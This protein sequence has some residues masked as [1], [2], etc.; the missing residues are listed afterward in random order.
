M[1]GFM[2]SRQLVL[3]AGVYR[4]TWTQSRE[5]FFHPAPLALCMDVRWLPSAHPPLATATSL[6]PTSPMYFLSVGGWEPV[7]FDLTTPWHRLRTRIAGSA[8]I[9]VNIPANAI[10]RT[11]RTI[12]GD[13]E[14]LDPVPWSTSIELYSSGE[15]WLDFWGSP[16]DRGPLVAPYSSTILGRIPATSPPAPVFGNETF[17]QWAARLGVAADPSADPDRDGMNSLLES[18]LGTDPAYPE[19]GA[20][21]M[22][23]GNPPTVRFLWQTHFPNDV[24]R[25]IETSSDLVHWTTAVPS[26]SG[27]IAEVLL[28]PPAKFARMRAVK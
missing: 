3:P 14:W 12:R 2:P 6:A 1:T 7:P 26:V 16:G 27:G 5:A 20:W 9:M 24:T 25:T 28:A 23:P 19:F 4:V 18:A 17:A 21:E 10:G 8:S 22:V 15:Q 13:N 11:I